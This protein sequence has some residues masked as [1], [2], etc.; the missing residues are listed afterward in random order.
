MGWLD[1]GMK[2]GWIDSSEGYGVWIVS[3]FRVGWI[4]NRSVS[5]VFV[6]TVMNGLN[7]LQPSE[8]IAAIIMCEVWVDWM[9][10]INSH[11]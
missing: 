1:G 5:G 8:T 4:I 2:M 9:D 3:D 7:L 10:L 11:H 6:M